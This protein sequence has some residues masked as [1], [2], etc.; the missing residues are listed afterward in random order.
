MDTNDRSI[1]NLGNGKTKKDSFTTS[2]SSQNPKKD[3][4]G[5]STKQTDQKCIIISKRKEALI[6]KGFLFLLL[7]CMMDHTKLPLS[8][9]TSSLFFIFEYPFMPRVFASALNSV[10]FNALKSTCSLISCLSTFSLLQGS[11]VSEGST[12]DNFAS[13]TSGKVT[14]G[15]GSD[16]RSGSS[17]SSVSDSCSVFRSLSTWFFSLFSLK[18]T[19]GMVLIVSS[20]E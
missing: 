3:L 11:S 19:W 5:R 4:K 16:S 8:N 20:P 1:K 13:W 7:S 12:S 10:S 6:K 2:P 9:S 15:S 18:F 17:S 14:T